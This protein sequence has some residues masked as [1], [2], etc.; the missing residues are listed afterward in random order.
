MEFIRNGLGT[1]FREKRMEFIR[2]FKCGYFL[3]HVL[4]VASF[5][6]RHQYKSCNGARRLEKRLK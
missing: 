3:I 1:A 6:K 2:N 5:N 4:L